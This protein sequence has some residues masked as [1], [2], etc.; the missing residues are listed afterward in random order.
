LLSDT[1]PPLAAYQPGDYPLFRAKY[2]LI[3]HSEAFR[4]HLDARW[5]T[6]PPCPTALSLPRT[7]HSAMWPAGRTHPV[8]Q[9]RVKPGLRAGIV[10]E[11]ATL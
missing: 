7:V 3:K 9:S 11:P 10:V 1:T 6:S 2:D 5:K 8:P 4:L